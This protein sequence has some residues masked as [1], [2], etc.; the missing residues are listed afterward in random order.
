MK[1]LTLTFTDDEYEYIT[2]F[3]DAPRSWW[4]EGRNALR[5]AM[6]RDAPVEPA[7]TGHD[8]VWLMEHEG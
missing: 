6:N 7:V 3:L 8:T 1:T 2:F 4:P 5:S